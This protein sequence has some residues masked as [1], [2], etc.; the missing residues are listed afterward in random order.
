VSDGTQSE[1]ERPRWAHEQDGE[2]TFFR[3]GGGKVHIANHQAP[4]P[5]VRTCIEQL[6][7]DPER[8]DLIYAWLQ[9]VEYLTGLCGVVLK[10]GGITTFDD[11]DFCWSCLNTLTEEERLVAFSHPLPQDE[12]DA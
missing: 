8:E 12:E 4:G 5:W 7:M 6:D 11:E 10:A 1:V 3:K 9:D 2:M